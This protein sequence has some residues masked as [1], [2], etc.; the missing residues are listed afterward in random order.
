MSATGELGFLPH[1]CIEILKKGENI[2]ETGSFW[3]I[4]DFSLF[5]VEACI[6]MLVCLDS[7]NYMMP[8][9]VFFCK[10]LP[11]CSTLAD[12]IITRKKKRK[13]SVA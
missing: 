6:L 10:L 1:S 9:T 11:G 12:K 2:E 13:H 3:V 5:N 7:S 8:K 4:Y